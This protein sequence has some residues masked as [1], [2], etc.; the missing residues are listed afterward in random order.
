MSAPAAF[1]GPTLAERERRWQVV[2]A[3]MQ[4]RGLDCLIV[5]GSDSVY[6]D[7]CQNLRYLTNAPR[8]GYLVF[9]SEADPTFITFESGL[10]PVWVQDWRGGVPRFSQ[11]IGAR[12]SELGL[13][14][15]RIGTVGTGGFY[16]E[17]AGFPYRTYVS[18][19]EAFPHAELVEATDLVEAVRRVKSDEEIRCLE[20]GCKIVEA[21][22][23]AVIATAAVGVRDI[24]VRAVILDTLFR[25]G[26]EQGAM[27]LYSQGKNVMHGGQRG[28][29]LER[30]RQERLEHGDVILVE[31]DA[32]WHGYKA[33]FNQPFVI[34]EPIGDWH[35]IFQTAS[36]CFAAGM[37]VLR[38]GVSVGEL[39]STMLAP[40]AAADLT[41]GNPAFHGLG[42]GIESPVGTYP[43]GNHRADPDIVI[44]QNMVLELEPH[45]ITTDFRR[46]A[47]VG[48]PVLV[49]DGGCKLIPRAW[50]AAPIVI[51]A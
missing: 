26:C 3:A 30:G 21:V 16:G 22:F 7:C 42:L 11:A 1:D 39:E 40:I 6:R 15:A 24:D 9:P 34:G 27:L 50:S 31:V 46:G 13:E 45:P 4:A 8:E 38:P 36:R 43:R 12:I 18:L 14:R 28:A 20:E 35:T 25:N 51:A 48:A 2:R 49:V 33:Q 32:V 47:S 23:A 41:F 29:R 5:Y 19:A 44:E 17:T 10:D 37:D